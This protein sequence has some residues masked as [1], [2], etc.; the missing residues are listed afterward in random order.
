MPVSISVPTILIELAIFLLM[1]YVL[2]RWVF[3]P[4]RNAWAE[5]DRRIQEGLQATGT[6]REELEQARDE[7]RQILAQ[8]RHEAQQQV[9]QATA[10]ADAVREQ[11]VAQATAEFRRLVDGARGEIAAQ[12]EQSA[13]AL[14]ERV[15]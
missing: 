15:V 11:L 10:D 2:E 14:Q 6:G 7:V 3:S 1:V 5:R 13:R 8:A 9:D 12:R 4:I